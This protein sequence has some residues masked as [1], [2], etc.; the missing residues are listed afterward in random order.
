ML[1]YDQKVQEAAAAQGLLPDAQR[2]TCRIEHV[3]RHV[4]Q[5]VEPRW[6][7]VAQG[8]IADDEHGAG[9]PAF[10][11]G[12]EVRDTKLVYHDWAT[13]LASCGYS[14]LLCDGVGKFAGTS[15]T[16]GSGWAKI[17]Q[18]AMTWLE[19]GAKGG[20][21]PEKVVV[22]GIFTEPDTRKI[23]EDEFAD[24]LRARGMDATASHKIVSD[25]EMPDK[26]VVIGKIRKL[27][28]DAVLVT[29]VMDM[30]K[31][32][33]HVP[34]Q[35]IAV[36]VYYVDYGAY[37]SHSYYQ[38]G[39]TIQG[40]HASTETNLYGLGDEKLIWSGRSKT[41]LSATRYEL[42]QAFVKTM[43]DGLSEARLIR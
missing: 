22:V 21:N 26:D 5:V 7:P 25:A 19:A 1:V 17:I 13:R 27:G 35:G 8:G 36:P 24:R 10:A 41:K 43:L 32:N 33:I 39:R 15:G 12:Q 40:G 14:T 3:D 30:E 9:T 42:I 18:H 20:G 38:P 29:R 6:A 37:Y 16:T 28:A 31:E 34:G 23:F 11:L 2:G 4:E